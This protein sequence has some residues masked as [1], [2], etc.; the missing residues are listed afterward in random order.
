M[1]IGLIFEENGVTQQQYEQVLA[2]IWPGNQ[3]PPGMLYHVAGV[4]EH[5]IIVIDIWDSPESV[6]AFE[7][8]TPRQARVAAHI[9]S[10][11][12]T[13]FLLINTM[14][15]WYTVSHVR[16]SPSSRGAIIHSQRFGV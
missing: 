16:T 10:H 7:A 6:H 5:G 4:G 14:Q 1:A 15:P 2:Q 13:I 11:E 3:P 9:T 12:V 8:E